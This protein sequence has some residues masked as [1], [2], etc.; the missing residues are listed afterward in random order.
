ME[1]AQG[2]VEAAAPRDRAQNSSRFYNGSMEGLDGTVVP[3]GALEEVGFVGSRM[4]RYLSRRWMSQLQRTDGTSIDRVIKGQWRV[5][6]GDHHELT[7]RRLY[8]A[9]QE[10]IQT[11]EYELP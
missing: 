11:S 9:W 7:P 8:T 6:D 5:E 1:Q 3:E 10:P 2:K 4:S